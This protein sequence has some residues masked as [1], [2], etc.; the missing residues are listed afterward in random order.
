MKLSSLIFI[1]L[2]S[3]IPVQATSL[4]GLPDLEILDI[5]FYDSDGETLTEIPVNEA[6]YPVLN[7]INKGN[8][9]IE[10]NVYYTPGK[11]PGFGI[12]VAASSNPEYQK[13][14]QYSGPYENVLNI[15]E[16]WQI[17]TKDRVKDHGYGYWLVTHLHGG[18]YFGSGEPMSIP[19]NQELTFDLGKPIDPTGFVFPTPG[20]YYAFE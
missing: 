7:V 20:V 12:E 17:L 11:G 1:L 10:S 15:P 18:F 9:P 2:V 3:I 13:L 4:A 5:N 19:I 16:F 8:I 14:V 6:V